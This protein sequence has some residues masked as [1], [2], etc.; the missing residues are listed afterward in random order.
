MSDGRFILFGPLFGI[1]D[2]EQGIILPA[3]STNRKNGASTAAQLRCNC[4]RAL[5]GYLLRGFLRNEGAA[6]RGRESYRLFKD[7]GSHAHS[8]DR[9]S[10]CKG[11]PATRRVGVERSRSKGAQGSLFSD[12]DSLKERIRIDCESAGDFR[13]APFARGEPVADP[14]RK[15][16]K[17]LPLFAY[18]NSSLSSERRIVPRRGRQSRQHEQLLLPKVKHRH[19]SVAYFPIPRR[20]AI[21]FLRKRAGILH[22]SPYRDRL[23][24]LCH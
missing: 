21:S 17:I 2:I 4:E 12:P 24:R 15:Q 5:H 20:S 7:R 14:A 19:G 13:S 1:A 23:L 3:H 22:R 16:R 9:I 18:D 6:P 8:A 10:L 11:S